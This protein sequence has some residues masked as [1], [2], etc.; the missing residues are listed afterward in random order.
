MTNRAL[1]KDAQKEQSFSQ[2]LPRPAWTARNALELRHA[3]Q[4]P[5]W[6]T[7]VREA[8]CKRV[9]SVSTRAKTATQLRRSARSSA[10]QKSCLRANYFFNVG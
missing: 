4:L 6:C 7:V 5:S 1:A 2:C 10:T 8:R 9:T 3:T